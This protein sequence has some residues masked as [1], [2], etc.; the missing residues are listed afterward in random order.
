MAQFIERV[1][2]VCKSKQVR[3]TL[4]VAGIAAGI[5]AIFK[6]GEKVGKTGEQMKISDRLCDVVI[7]RYDRHPTVKVGEYNLDVIGALID[8]I[9]AD[10]I[11]DF[12]R[13]QLSKNH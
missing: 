5:V 3:N 1:K 11:L 4:T 7:D 6:L 12:V 2:K 9:D 8:D 10:V 13:D